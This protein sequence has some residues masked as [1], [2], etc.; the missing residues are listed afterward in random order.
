MP[1]ISDD[2]LQDL[3]RNVVVVHVDGLYIVCLFEARAPELAMLYT[4]TAP[5]AFQRGRFRVLFM[6][7]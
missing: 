5:R 2:L 3:Q 4:S 6:R 1:Y 7:I